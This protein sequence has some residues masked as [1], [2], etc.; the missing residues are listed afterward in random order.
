MN[1]RIMLYRYSINI[2]MIQ[3]F[4]FIY[5]SVRKH[6]KASEILSVKSFKILD[7]ESITVTESYSILV[8]F[9]CAKPNFA[10]VKGTRF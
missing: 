1:I 9:W 7:A 8:R 2:S 6:V 4:Y 5:I 10:V 3:V